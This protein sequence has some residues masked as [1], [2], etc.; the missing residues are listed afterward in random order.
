MPTPCPGQAPYA[1]WWPALPRSPTPTGRRAWPATPA[2]RRLRTWLRSPATEVADRRWRPVPRRG[3]LLADPGLGPNGVSRRP[4]PTAWS[5][6]RSAQRR[7]PRPP[8]RQAPAATGCL[9]YT[10]DAADDLTRVDL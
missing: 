9:L 2:G 7:C 3:Q 6:G 1:G 8:I 10:S 4:R 5:P